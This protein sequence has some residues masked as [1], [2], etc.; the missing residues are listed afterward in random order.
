MAKLL[1][2][3][4]THARTAPASERGHVTTSIEPIGM[5]LGRLIAA[6]V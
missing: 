2:A 1:S 5:R 4:R 3:I 6:R